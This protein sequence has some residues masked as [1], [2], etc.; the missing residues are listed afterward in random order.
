VSNPVAVVLAAGKGTRMRSALPK[1][2]FPLL[3]TPIVQRVVNAATGAGCE[4]VVAVV[5]HEA[6]MVEAALAGTG[7]RFATQHTRRGTGDAVAAAEPAMGSWDRPVLIL[8]GDV[9]RMTA[10]TLSALIEAHSQSGAAVTVGTMEPPEPF[11]YGRIVRDDAGVVAI[12]EHRDCTPAQRAIGECNTGLYVAS[13]SFLFGDGGALSRLTNNNDQGE[14]YLTDIV[15]IARGDGLPVAGVLIDDPGEVEGI[16]DRAQLAAMEK[17]ARERAAKRWMQAGVSMDDPCSVRIEDG[18]ELAQDVTLGADVE[19]RGTC[20]IASGAV[21][22]RGSILTDVVVGPDATVGPY[23]VL[24]RVTIETNALVRPFTVATG[25]NEKKPHLTSHEDRVHIGAGAKVGPFTHLRQAAN[26]EEDVHV[27]NFVELKKTTMH[28]GSKANHLAY[29]GDAEIGSK[30]NIGAGV[31]TCNYDGF[32]KHKTTVGEGAFV[33][34]DSHLIAPVKIGDG[35][36]V[37][38]GTTVTKDVPA[39]GLAIGRTRQENKAGRA[40]KLKAVLKRRAEAGKKKD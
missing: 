34:T 14:L 6:A 18:V 17:A 13:G 21:I 11:G 24:E 40:S 4:D 30:S 15:G 32:A 25:L 9:P 10:G 1:V 38:T 26:L 28:P 7:V 12:V 37:A 5:G 19:L 3:G 22:K 8:P 20:S 23:V 16:N 27:G 2:L 36:Y 39:D 35:A 33:G 31:I 29:L